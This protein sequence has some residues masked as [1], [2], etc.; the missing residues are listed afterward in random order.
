MKIQKLHIRHVKGVREIDIHAN[1]TCNE[2]AGPNGAG[3]SSVLDSIV[4]ALGGA[5]QIDRRPLRDGEGKGEILITTDDG[6]EV[7]RRFAEGRSPTLTVREKGEKRGQRDLNT[8][9]SDF[10][11]D[12]LAFSRMKPAQQIDTLQKL[13]GEEFC[14]QLAQLDADIATKFN[15]RRGLRRDIDKVGSIPNV[16]K[17]ERVDTVQLIGELEQLKKYNAEQEAL[18][19]ARQEYAEEVRRAKMNVEAAQATL[20]AA[21]EELNE[22]EF[23]LSQAPEPKPLEDESK[24]VQAIAEAGSVNSKAD[25]YKRY[26]E[27]LNELELLNKQ[28]LALDETIARLRDD[29]EQLASSVQ[30]PVDGVSFS[31]SGIRVHGIPFDQL[32]SSEQIRVS[33]RI[34]AAV[35][36]TLRIM[37]IKDGS[38]LDETSFT[39]LVSIAEVENVQLWVETVGEG[40]GDA[41]HIEAGELRDEF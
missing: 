3:K 17:V 30:L 22:A 41:I 19:R 33:A 15:D 29:R 13:A 6:W 35:N 18:K 26:K 25:E 8:L 16:E 37:L 23:Y 31:D 38:L 32:S 20:R 36:N 34:G 4:F 14:G 2:I 24:L 12:P 11:F 7:I 27:R 39:E 10:S 5:K 1:Q 21:Q 9:F 28:C 40:H